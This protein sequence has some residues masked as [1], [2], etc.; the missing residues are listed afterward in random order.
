M[1]NIEL[2]ELEEI[3]IG[4]KMV[5]RSFHNFQ[6]AGSII[7][8]AGNKGKFNELLLEGE[9]AKSVCF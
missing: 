1:R 8:T 9:S 6:Y 7:L 4:I 5:R 3:L 2:E